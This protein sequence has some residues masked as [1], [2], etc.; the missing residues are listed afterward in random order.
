MVAA[1][2]TQ[3]VRPVSLKAA[4]AALALALSVPAWSACNPNIRLTRPDSRYEAVAG[5][6]PFDSEV[7]DK[8]TGLVWQR[9][10]LGMVWGGSTCTGSA[11]GYTWM[12][13]LEAARTAAASSVRGSGAWRLPD[14]KELFSLVES[15]CVGPAINSTWFPAQSGGYAWSSSPLARHADFA[16]MVIFDDGQHNAI[17]TGSAAQVRLVRSSQ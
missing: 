17:N 10:L 9:C 2:G 4:C 13:A 15:A 14:K 12:Q 7:R 1:A 5:A 8:V 6:A 3:V 11:T 16:W